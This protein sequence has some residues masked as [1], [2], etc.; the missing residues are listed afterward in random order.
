MPF[1]RYIET[2][3]RSLRRAFKNGSCRDWP[4]AM[5][6][7]L[8]VCF[9]SI[10]LSLPCARQIQPNR[11]TAAAGNVE[12]YDHCASPPLANPFRDSAL[13]IIDATSGCMES[14]QVTFVSRFSHVNCLL[15]SCR[16]AAIA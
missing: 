9:T 12:P 16:V 2:G 15:A 5:G 3:T 1:T 14:N 8:V 6:E 11:S 13:K 4:R 10:A 7:L